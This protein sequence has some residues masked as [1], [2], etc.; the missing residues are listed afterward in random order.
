M[1]L[2]TGKNLMLINTNAVK[3]LWQK[4]CLFSSIMKLISLITLKSQNITLKSRKYYDAEYLCLLSFISFSH[5]LRGFSKIRRGWG[6]VLIF[7]VLQY[8]SLE[9]CILSSRLRHNIFVSKMKSLQIQISKMKLVLITSCRSG[10]N[11]LQ[12]Q[13]QNKV[14]L[15]LK[16]DSKQF[17]T[18]CENMM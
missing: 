16:K 7:G 4:N 9:L 2:Y 5:Q 1:D 6:G 18:S 17:Q 15:R 8:I 12:K 3:G 11:F 13:F 10:F 14:K